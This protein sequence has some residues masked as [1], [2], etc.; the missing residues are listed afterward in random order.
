MGMRSLKGPSGK[1]K[2][3]AQAELPELQSH[4]AGLADRNPTPA[5]SGP[6]T[7]TSAAPGLLHP[8]ACLA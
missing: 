3:W 6:G 7:A 4:R 8:G 5:A 2:D 1:R